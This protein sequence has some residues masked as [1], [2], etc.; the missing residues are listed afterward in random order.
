MQFATD[1]VRLGNPCF[2]SCA[3]SCMSS[4]IDIHISYLYNLHLH[5]V[6]STAWVIVNI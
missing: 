1:T 2:N 6:R 3:W 5:V 4:C